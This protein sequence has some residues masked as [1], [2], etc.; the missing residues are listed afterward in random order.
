MV[1]FPSY[2]MLEDVYEIYE[3]EFSVNWVHCICQNS[4]MNE[5]EREEFLEKFQE[6]SGI[7]SGILYYGWDFF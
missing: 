6:K 1:F 7:S 2:K 3:E 5:K 4:S